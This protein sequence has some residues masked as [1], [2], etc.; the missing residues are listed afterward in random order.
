MEL[1]R[2][3]Y[4][5]GELE[6]ECIDLEELSEIECAFDEIPLNELRDLPENAMAVDMLDELESR[7]SIVEKSI[8]NWVVEG[9]GESEANDPSWNIGLLADAIN[10]IPVNVNGKELTI[11][12]LL[13]GG[14]DGVGNNNK[15]PSEH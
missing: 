12:K 5:R 15:T 3:K 13:D 7:V 4:L 14:S 8:Y 1:T 11:Y 6:D 9:F 2:I 10:S